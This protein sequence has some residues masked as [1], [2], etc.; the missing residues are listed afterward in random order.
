VYADNVI[1][2]MNDHTG[3]VCVMASEEHDDL[4]HI[5]DHFTPG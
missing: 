3:R 4:L 5:P 2:R 1:F